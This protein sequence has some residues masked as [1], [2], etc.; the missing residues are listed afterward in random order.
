[1]S[2]RYARLSRGIQKLFRALDALGE[3]A[4]LYLTHHDEVDVG[5]E[6]GAQILQEP[7]VCLNSEIGLHGLELDQ[8]IDVALSRYEVRT[9]CGAESLK[10][11]H[12][13][14]FAG[15]GSFLF[16]LQKGLLS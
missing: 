4:V 9:Q 7:K 2:A 8:K 1:M 16:L 5:L 10:A 3:E 12:A 13:L 6:Q 15:G 11:R 14:A